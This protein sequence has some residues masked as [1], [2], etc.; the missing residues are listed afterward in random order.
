MSAN[1][2]SMTVVGH[3][4]PKSARVHCTPELAS[5]TDR[6]AS[7]SAQQS[8]SVHRALEHRLIVV[9]CQLNN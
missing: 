5:V 3:K 7:D 1:F 2:L 4:G 9:S 6:F 8:V